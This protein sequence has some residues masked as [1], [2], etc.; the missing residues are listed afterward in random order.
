M[1]IAIVGAGSLGSLFACLLKESGREVVLVERN[2]KTIRMIRSKGIQ[3]ID[4]FG[5][6][7][8]VRVD[9]SLSPR[10]K[11]PV[12]ILLLFVKSYDTHAAIRCTQHVIGPE[13]LVGSFQNGL[14]NLEM[15]SE[16][17][18]KERIFCGSLAYSA[19]QLDHNKVRYT[20]GSGTLKL[21]KYDN[22]MT[23]AFREVIGVFEKIGYPLEVVSDYETSLWNKL[24]MNAGANALS[25][26]TGL[27]CGEMVKDDSLQALMRLTIQEAVQVAKRKGVKIDHSED[28]AQPLFRALEGIGMNK[29]TMLQDFERGSMIEI[30]AINGAIVKEGEKLGVATPVNQLL[31]LL[32]DHL[33]KRRSLLLQEKEKLSAHPLALPGLLKTAKSE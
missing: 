15:I 19:M 8:N 14:G 26:I 11:G 4:P 21:A 6:E 16:I 24:L 1:R 33:W 3:L 27:N 30:E 18:P 23:A 5:E 25:T 2:R 31:V 29:T 12:D 22:Q 7:R 10:L 9:I 32:T 28:P 20:G 13:T 17:V